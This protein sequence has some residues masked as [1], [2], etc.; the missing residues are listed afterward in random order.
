[1]LFFF[2]ETVV[3]NGRFQVAHFVSFYIEECV[4]N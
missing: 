3:D 1:M 2:F 4:T